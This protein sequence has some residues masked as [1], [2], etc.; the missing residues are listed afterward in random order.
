[1]A[2]KLNIT[3]AELLAAIIEG[4]FDALKSE[5]A[6]EC[7]KRMHASITRKSDVPKQPSKAAKENQALAIKVLEYMPI[8]ETVLASDVMQ[9]VKGIMTSQKC[10][11]VMGV[12]IDAGKVVKVPKAKGRYTGYKLV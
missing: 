4:D 5:D 3:R 7:A 6:I 10:A 11:K 12:L 1:M 2:E 9:H 8:G